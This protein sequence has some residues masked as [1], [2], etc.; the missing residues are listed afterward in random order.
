MR[1]TARKLMSGLEQDLQRELKLAGVDLGRGDLS[2]R[3]LQRSGVAEDVVV[4]VLAVRIAEIRAVRG[5]VYL[6]TEL[7]P[8]GFTQPADLSVLGKG[9]VQ[10]GDSGRG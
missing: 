9:Y 3:G 7:Q 4:R 2:R 10:I 8:A 6:R 1:A 5:V